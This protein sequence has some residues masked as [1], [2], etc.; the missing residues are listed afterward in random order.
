MSGTRCRAGE[1][2]G[3]L[4]QGATGQSNR[5]VQTHGGACDGSDSL[6]GRSGNARR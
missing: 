3:P 1:S 2:K 5:E 6:G 4:H